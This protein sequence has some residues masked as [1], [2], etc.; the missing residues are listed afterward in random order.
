MIQE[1]VARDL[2]EM[3]EESL[4]RDL[5][6]RHPDL[7]PVVDRLEIDLDHL[8]NRTLVEAAMRHGYEPGPVIEEAARVIEAGRR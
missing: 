4:L 5:L 2:R 6:E 7:M 8:E 1:Y 3:L